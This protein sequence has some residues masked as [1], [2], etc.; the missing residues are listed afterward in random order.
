MTSEKK[1]AATD[2][3]TMIF[4]WRAT[5]DIPEWGLVAGQEVRHVLTPG[6]APLFSAEHLKELTESG[7][8]EELERH[9]ADEIARFLD[10]TVAALV[11]HI[12]PA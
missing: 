9:S 7:A 10:A 5:R 4:H 1:P 8:L 3:P 6:E 12:D 2:A 11:A